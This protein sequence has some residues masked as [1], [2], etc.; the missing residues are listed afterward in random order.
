MSVQRSNY[1]TA[2]LFTF[3]ELR[4]ITLSNYFLQTMLQCLIPLE[5][6]SLQRNFTPLSKSIQTLRRWFTKHISRQKKTKNKHP[7]CTIK[8][9]LDLVCVKTQSDKKAAGL[10][11]LPPSVH[12][13][14]RKQL[15]AMLAIFGLQ[16]LKVNQSRNQRKNLLF[17]MH[18]HTTLATRETHI[19]LSVCRVWMKS[20]ASDLSSFCRNQ[21]WQPVTPLSHSLNEASWGWRTGNDLTK[22]NEYVTMLD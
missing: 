15:S 20:K 5:L 13:G 3:V 6:W 4:C 10:S 1:F 7:I 9:M 17:N 11:S 2:P 18:F 16:K 8:Q 22:S 19:F 14:G 12:A 21:N